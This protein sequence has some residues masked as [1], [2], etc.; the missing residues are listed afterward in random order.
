MEQQIPYMNIIAAVA[1]VSFALF[2]IIPP[3]LKKEK[4]TRNLAPLE[5]PADANIQSLLRE[6]KKI[7]AIKQYKELY[8]TSLKD[9][10]DAVDDMESARKL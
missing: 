3:L 8:N 1:V 10:K 5:R 4:G 7:E 9:A 2:L 6:G